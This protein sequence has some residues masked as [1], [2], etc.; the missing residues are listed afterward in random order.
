M[1]NLCRNQDAVDVG[2]GEEVVAVDEVVHKAL[3]KWEGLFGR[4]NIL[5]FNLF[6][7][8]EPNMASSPQQVCG[9]QNV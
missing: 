2:Y 5:F 9:T 6:L 8:A 1:V 7:L 4:L 3:T